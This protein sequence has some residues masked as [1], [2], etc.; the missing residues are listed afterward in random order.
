[1]SGGKGMASHKRS[2][3]SSTIWLTPRAIIWSLG[4]FDL[5]PCAAPSPRPWPTAKR[6]IELPEDGLVA[7]WVGRVWLN[8]PYGKD[9]GM[10]EWIRKM[11]GHKSGIALIFATTDTVL[12]KDTIWP[13]CDA[14]L[15]VAGRLSFCLPDGTTKS[16]SGGPSV[17]ISWSSQDTD[18]MIRSGIQG[19][20]V[21]PLR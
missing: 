18:S 17:L 10:D 19:Q 9:C 5:D 16:G 4:E 14:V 2:N 1:M 11:A 3:E 12:W 21:K 13:N 20:I 8:P 7:E 6:H 15:F